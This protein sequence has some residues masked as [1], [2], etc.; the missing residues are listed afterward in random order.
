[1]L[2]MVINK[3]PFTV[4]YKISL[5]LKTLK[6]QISNIYKVYIYPSINIGIFYLLGMAKS[7]Y[8]WKTKLGG[9][10]SGKLGRTFNIFLFFF[11]FVIKF[12]NFII[13]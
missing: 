4:C 12:I 11:N 6:L 1:M 8:I 7:N 2:N 13:M 3:H 5:L 10:Y 9:G